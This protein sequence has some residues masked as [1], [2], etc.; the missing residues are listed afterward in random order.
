MGIDVSTRRGFVA[1]VIA[2][3]VSG[4]GICAAKGG[5]GAAQQQPVSHQTPAQANQAAQAQAQADVQSAQVLQC[6][7]TRVCCVQLPHPQSYSSWTNVLSP[8]IPFI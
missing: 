2:L 4:S 1:L 5:N 8:S 7:H 3:L 6:C